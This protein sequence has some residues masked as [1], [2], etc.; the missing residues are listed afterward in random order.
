MK[1]T[2]LATYLVSMLILFGLCAQDA[3]LSGYLRNLKDEP[4][5]DVFV[6]VKGEKGPQITDREGY[7]S[8][9]LPVQQ[10]YILS[11][12]SIRIDPLKRELLLDGDT[13]LTIVTKELVQRLEEVVVEA[14]SDAFGIRQLRSIEAGG[15]YEG[16]KTEVINIQKMTGNKAAN[17]ARQAY[18]K[19]PSLNIWE[20]D[21]A[22][23]QLDVGG[24]G[25]SPRRTSNFNV[26]QNGY[27]ISADP[28]GY[29]ESYYTPPLQAIQQI[30][31][32]RGAGALQYGS[33]FGGLINFKLRRGAIDKPIN[34]ESENTY[35][36]FNFFN[37]FNSIHGQYKKLNHYSYVQYKR[38]DCFRCNSAFDLYS[39]HT[40]LRYDA[41]SKLNLGFDFTHMYYLT[42]QGGGL[43]DEQFAADHLQ[44][45]R[46]RNWFR[47]GWTLPAFLLEYQIYQNVKIY[48][49]TY[50]LVA[51]RSS[52]GLLTT[53]NQADAPD[54]E[55]NFQNRDLID[56]KF[57]N[58][59]NETR[60]SYTYDTKN[61]LKNSLL[62]GTRIYNGFTN[63]SQFLGTTGDDASF[64]RV[65]TA[66]ANRRKS[67]FDFPSLNVAVF[68]EK[69]IRFSETFSLIPGIRYEYIRTESEG[70]RIIPIEINS[71]DDVIEQTSSQSDQKTRRILMYGLGLSKKLND[72]YELYANAT[73]N[74]RAINFTDIQIQT[75]TQLV[76]TLIVDERGYSVDLGVR[77]QDFD[78]FFLEAGLF[79]LQYNNRI[80]EVLDDDLRI[81]TNIGD[82]RIF[83]IEVFFEV[84]LLNA[85]NK[86]TEH[87]LS[88]FTNGSLN[89][90][91]YTNINERTSNVVRSGKKLQEI[92]L[93]N[94]KTGILYGFRKFTSSLQAV[95]IGEQ[96]SDAANTRVRLTGLQETT[97]V[98]GQ[99]PAYAVVD[100][101]CKYRL[102]KHFLLSGSINNLLN[103]KYFT[104]RATAYPGPG[105]IPS[106]PRTYYLTLSVKI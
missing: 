63:F 60:I 35:G 106:G 3:A 99:I 54:Q 89:R 53:P 74:Y 16:K 27:D 14:G 78:P 45:T 8:F 88:F 2:R 22:G 15:L 61:N 104:R 62:V 46:A 68:A 49:R 71:F 43:T 69:I 12:Q 103:E 55:G 24:R 21:C 75:N 66:I 87:K 82:A 86:T 20:S 97:G 51:R 59:G 93:Y 6:Y 77:R 58:L 52:L 30:E 44:S 4:I 83:G 92:P 73:S 94:I 29:P 31:I 100:F 65:D 50:G 5:E 28:L 80:D 47:V 72:R 84:D 26:R 18:S 57:R 42:Q 101:S 11:F 91:V 34:V 64:A 38:G 23:L 9:T 85:L 13:T 36:S 95:F 37:T 102:S 79:F 96:F 33:Q 98:F 40:S 70:T 105:I 25:L 76:D 32:V 90:G 48:S 10:Q 56:G 41:S 67:D 39:A 17:N 7:F 81:R 1:M 19:I